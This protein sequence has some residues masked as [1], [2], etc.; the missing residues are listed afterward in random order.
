MHVWTDSPNEEMWSQLRYLAKSANVARLLAGG[1]DSKRDH[2]WASSEADRSAPEISACIRQAD[3]YFQAARNVSLATKPLMLFYG[4][5]SLAKSVILAND[6][7]RSLSDFTYHGLTTSARAAKDELRE[8][9]AQYSRDPERW[10]LE[11]EYAVVNSGVFPYLCEALGDRGPAHREVITYKD[12]IRLLPDMRDVFERHYGENHESLSIYTMED[13]DKSNALFFNERDYDKIDAKFPEI[14]PKGE[15]K[16]LH[17]YHAGYTGLSLEDIPFGTLQYG[18]VAGRYLVRRHSTGISHSASAL[19]VSMFI[20]SN[21]VRY[22]PSFWMKCVDDGNVGSLAIVEIMCKIFER[23]FPNDVLESIWNEKF[24][25]G[26]PA[27][28]Q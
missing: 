27:R 13:D 20:L 16:I 8:S 14:S 5:Q 9:L 23:R 22:K 18:T 1:I 3:E 28:F 2:I 24:S 21:V 26:P 10:T 11:E 7:S 17:T 15:R 12:T 6:S 4:A 25:Y 19:F